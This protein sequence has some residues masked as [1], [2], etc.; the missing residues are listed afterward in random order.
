MDEMT[1]FEYANDFESRLQARDMEEANLTIESHY[2]D[3]VPVIDIYAELGEQG[4]VDSYMLK[5]VSIED[6]EEDIF[7][8]WIETFEDHFE[9]TINHYK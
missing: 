8:A 7:D 6:F 2:E 3:N 5:H 4:Y 1:L 9:G